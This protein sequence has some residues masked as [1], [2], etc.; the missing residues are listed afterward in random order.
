ME[1]DARHQ[2]KV[3]LFYRTQYKGSSEFRHN[4]KQRLPMHQ[5]ETDELYISKSDVQKLIFEL[6]WTWRYINNHEQLNA[7]I[8]DMY[9]AAV[10]EKNGNVMDLS[11]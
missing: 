11:D 2:L 9:N 5:L 8:F 4:I 3:T 10:E 1:T 7:E 6:S